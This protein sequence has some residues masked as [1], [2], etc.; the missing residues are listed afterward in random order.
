MRDR[1]P[2]TDPTMH[3]DAAGP[4]AAPTDRPA[5]PARAARLATLA[6]AVLAAGCTL[7]PLADTP[8]TTQEP[9]A[10]VS[11]DLRGYRLDLRAGERVEIRL[12]GNRSTGYRWVLVDPVPP[13]VRQVEAARYDAVRTDL[14][15]APG[16]ETWLFEAA[17]RGAGQLMFEY[18][19][20]FDPPT[21]PPA[22][23]SS[24]RVEVR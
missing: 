9:A 23:R 17:A 7:S 12:P 14:S 22:Q 11:T 16:T 5:R 3:L 21:V 24:Y 1:T 2:V 20:P 4:A 6:T 13:M 8:P 10:A 15:G 18:R 19:R